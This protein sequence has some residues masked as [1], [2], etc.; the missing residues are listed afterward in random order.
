MDVAYKPSFLRQFKKLPIPLQEEVFEKIEMFKNITN[1]PKLKVH[2]LHGD[3]KNY[4][5]FS[6]NYRHRIVFIWEIQNKSAVLF[7]ISD[8]AVYS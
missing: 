5:S 6:V 4:F 1:H 3:L 8:H 7:A 2:K